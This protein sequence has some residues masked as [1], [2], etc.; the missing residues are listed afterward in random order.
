RWLA[1]D[2][3][4][5][6][7]LPLGGGRF[8]SHHSPPGRPAGRGIV[9][10]HPFGDEMN[11]ARRMAALQSRRLAAEGV[12]VL[13]IDLHGCGDSA[14]DCAEARWES[15][16]SDVRAALEWRRERVRGPLSLWGLRLGATLACDVARDAALALDYLVLWQP[17]VAG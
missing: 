1:A 17:V 3:T 5:V 4:S 8:C 15:W 11:K 12:S 6:F 13:Q 9:Y 14:G 10:V 2:V 16:V 7:F